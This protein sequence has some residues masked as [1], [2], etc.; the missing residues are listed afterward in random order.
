MSGDQT[1][2]KQLQDELNRLDVLNED[3]MAA[4]EVA[5]ILNTSPQTVCAWARAGNIPCIQ[6]PGGWRFPRT[7]V[8]QWIKRR[9]GLETQP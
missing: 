7:L 1:E 3:W 4:K 8:V 9:L 2:Y 5:R 6:L